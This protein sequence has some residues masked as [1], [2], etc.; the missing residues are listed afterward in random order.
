MTEVPKI[1]YDRLRA[2]RPQGDLPHPDA[3]LLAAFAERAL[4]ASERDG[5][6]KHLA[7]CE[8]CREVIAMALPDPGI[9]A[10]PAADDYEAIRVTVVPQKSQWNWLSRALGGSGSGDCGGSVDP[11]VAS[12]KAESDHSAFGKPAGRTACVRAS[13]CGLANCIF[14]PPLVVNGTN[15]N[16]A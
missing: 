2:A 13:G 14:S 16:L 5:M 1:V 3:G 11:P 10:V 7:L 4:S 9:V 12:G 8:D 6:L 15:E